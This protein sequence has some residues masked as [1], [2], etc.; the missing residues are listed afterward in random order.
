M[1]VMLATDGGLQN[2]INVGKPLNDCYGYITQAANTPIVR[3]IPPCDDLRS[4]LGSFQYKP[5]ATAHLLTCMVAMS[6]SLVTSEVASGGT[7]IP[8]GGALTAFDA[9]AIANGDYVIV[10]YEDGTWVPLVVSGVSALNLTVPAT[11]QK[12][13][14]GS[15][16]FMMGVAS[17]H[18][19]RGFQTVASTLY[20]FNAGDFRIRGATGSKK[21]SPLLMYSPNTTNAGFFDYVAFYFD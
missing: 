12:I 5:A 11:T 7:V 17:D 10:Q 8:V 21:A 2:N 13:L 4:C 20:T 6:E 3:V 1:G 19:N 15:K 16:I 9:S 18:P 14:K